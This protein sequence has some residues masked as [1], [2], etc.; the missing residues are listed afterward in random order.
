MYF[1]AFSPTSVYF[2]SISYVRKWF[3]PLYVTCVL[4][5]SDE[6]GFVL[7]F[8]RIRRRLCRSSVERRYARQKSE[9]NDKTRGRG[10]R[11]TA[12]GVSDDDSLG[13]PPVN[14][15][16]PPLSAA[17][18]ARGGRREGI[19]DRGDSVA[20]SYRSIVRRTRFRDGRFFFA[21]RSVYTHVYACTR[22]PANASRRPTRA[23][24]TCAR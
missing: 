16:G 15:S 18:G 19:F 17:V 10:P 21:D 22:A 9:R 7:I 13:A 3:T 11:P 14:H 4:F 8:A 12:V 5:F 24:Y 1:L 23:F 2:P 20:L 6:Y